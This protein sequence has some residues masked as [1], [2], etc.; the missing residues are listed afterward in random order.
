[1]NLRG[2]KI[3]TTKEYKDLLEHLG[4]SIIGSEILNGEYYTTITD[5]TGYKSYHFISNNE[6]IDVPEVETCKVTI[7]LSDAL[8][9]K[10]YIN[11]EF[12]E[13]PSDG[14]LDLNII[15]GSK[16]N[17]KIELEG[18]KTID[19]STIIKKDR[20]IKLNWIKDE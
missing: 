6:L 20:I 7:N 1:M 9:S 13:L 14:I 18:W 12:T 4:S 2:K 8:D 3:L 19:E 16:L 10:V 11:D 17:Y 5:S 15:K